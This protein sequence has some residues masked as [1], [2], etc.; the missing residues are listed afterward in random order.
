MENIPLFPSGMNRETRRCLISPSGLTAKRRPTMSDEAKR[1][2]IRWRRIFFGFHLL[3]WL[4]ARLAVGSIQ[5]MPPE[6]IYT[7][8]EVWAL[9]VALHAVLLAIAE[10][11]DR[12][13]LPITA[14]HRL[15]D[16]R[17]R[18]WTLLAIDALV[19]VLFTMMIASRVIPEGVIFQYVAP[20]SLAWLALTGMG[21]AHLLLV[22]YA[23]IRD[24]VPMSKRKNNAQVRHGETPL[25]TRDG[26]LLETIDEPSDAAIL[27]QHSKRS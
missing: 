14:L 19:W 13:D 24:R 4:M 15:I 8:L 22:L 10:G 20:L 23:E 9:G 3:L 16:P 21:M 25:L 27:Q 11:R 17:E 1:L 5:Q 26:E 6:A 7:L 18:R 12:A 2:N